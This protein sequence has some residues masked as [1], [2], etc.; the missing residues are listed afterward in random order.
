MKGI[1]SAA[2]CR[3]AVHLEM[4]QHSIPPNLLRIGCNR[5]IS[6]L[7][8]YQLS[9]TTTLTKT[10]AKN[11]SRHTSPP[12]KS[13]GAHSRPHPHTTTRHSTV[14]KIVKVTER[15]STKPCAA[16]HRKAQLH[17]PLRRPRILPLGHIGI[18][19]PPRRDQQ[20][21]SLSAKVLLMPDVPL[22]LSIDASLQF[23]AGFEEFV[24]R[25]NRRAAGLGVIEASPPL[26]AWCSGLE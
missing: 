21:P 22:G 3:L 20:R 13:R 2:K 5:E 11:R 8:V 17:S 12:I 25:G 10:I 16:V 7:E 18:A 1:I 4:Q 14:H 23:S 15:R 24:Q 19:P 26:L 9:T 6:H